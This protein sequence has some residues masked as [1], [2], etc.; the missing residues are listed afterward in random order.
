MRN[1]L[2]NVS[3]LVASYRDEIDTVTV[4]L[5][6][7]LNLQ[8]QIVAEMRALAADDLSVAENLDILPQNF[9]IMEC[10]PADFG[11][12]RQKFMHCS[13]FGRNKKRLAGYTV[14]KGHLSKPQEFILELF[15]LYEVASWF[16]KQLI[17]AADAVG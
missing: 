7:R 8:R 15:M 1:Y 13:I 3:R 2:L 9:L 6:I 16:G 11:T 12:F 17:V 4:D 14:V 5:L 10:K